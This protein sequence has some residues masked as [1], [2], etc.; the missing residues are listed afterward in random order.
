M[1]K[2]QSLKVDKGVSVRNSHELA[3]S[4][5]HMPKEVFKKHVTSTKNAFSSWLKKIGEPE[6]A[7]KISKYK[8]KD[9]MEKALLRELI[10]KM[11]RGEHNAPN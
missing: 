6:L 10:E 3:L 5:R 2:R 9:S 11:K 4:L 7:K 1:K 8:T